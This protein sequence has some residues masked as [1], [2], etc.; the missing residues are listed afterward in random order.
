[1]NT[2][3][4]FLS[5]IFEN[6]FQNILCL[7]GKNHFHPLHRCPVSPFQQFIVV[8][9]ILLII[10]LRK[11]IKAV[12]DLSLEVDI[13]GISHCDKVNRPL[14]NT[15]PWMR[16]ECLSKVHYYKFHFSIENVLCVSSPIVSLKTKVWLAASR[17]SRHNWCFSK[18]SWI[19]LFSD[20]I[21]Y[22]KFTTIF[23]VQHG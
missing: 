7:L 13:F 23:T 15:L 16:K 8:S 18:M 1:M 4:T 9:K 20:Q 22:F 2:T 19:K 6:L 12:T 5:L 14:K 21:V 17:R 10:I 11:I 3:F